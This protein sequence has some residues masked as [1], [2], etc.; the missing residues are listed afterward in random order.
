MKSSINNSS[1]FDL[2]LFF[3]IGFLWG[4]FATAGLQIHDEFFFDPIHSNFRSFIKNYPFK[5]P[6]EYK[7]NPY[8]DD[9]ISNKYVTN[10]N[11]D[12]DSYLNDFIDYAKMGFFSFD[13]SNIN[14]QT[15]TKFH[16][17]A[18]PIIDEQFLMLLLE[19]YPNRYQPSLREVDE[20]VQYI[21]ENLQKSSF[22]FPL[23]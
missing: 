1:D 15:D 21:L 16:L 22:D 9:L 18:Y 8:L 17:V 11:F 7:L 14:S 10:P 4:H 2:D 20:Y 6:F 5:R 13:R 3:G 23:R 19:F 12:L